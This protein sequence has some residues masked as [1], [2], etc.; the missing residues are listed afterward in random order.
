MAT[1]TKQFTRLTEHQADNPTPSASHRARTAITYS[2]LKEFHLERC[3]VDKDGKQRPK[4]SLKNEC[5]AINSWLKY[6]D[7]TPA[8]P[9]AE[10]LG[11]KFCQCLPQYLTALGQQ[12]LSERTVSDR[13]SIII[14]LRESFIAFERINDLPKNFSSALKHLIDTAS[15][16]VPELAHAT[17]I[18]KEVIITLTGG[19]RIPSCNSLAHIKRLERF[20]NL[21]PGTLSAKLPD[22]IWLKGPIRS[23]TTDWRKHQSG[24]LRLKYRLP[25]LTEQLQREWHEFMLSCTDSQWAN[26]QG[27]RTNSNW[28]VRWN[29]GRCGTAEFYYNLLQS[30]FGFL[31]LPMNEDKRI[32]GLGLSLPDLSLALLTDADLIMKY[33]YFMKGRSF[34]QSFNTATFNFLQLCMMLTRK[35]TGYLWQLPQFGAKLPRPVAESEWQSWCEKNRKKLRKF[36]KRIKRSKQDRVGMTRN[37]FEAVIDIIKERQHPITALFDLASRLESLTPLLEKGS[38][39]VLAAHRRSIFQV[40][41]ISSNPL[42]SENFSM[43]TYIPEDY[44]ALEQACNL[45]QQYKDR[46]QECDTSRLY[47]A[48]NSESNL[49]QRRDG[50][51]RLRFKEEDFKNWKGVALEPGVRRASY[52]VEVVPSVWP[53]LMEYLFRHRAVLNEGLLHVLRSIVSARALPALT[54]EQESAILRCPY[55]FRPFPSGI[56]AMPQDKFKIEYCSQQWSAKAFS[57]HMFSLTARYLPESKGFCAHACRHLVATEYIKNYPNGYEEAAVALHNTADMVR[58]HYSWVEV[59]DLIKPWSN[60]HE[61]IKGKHDRGEV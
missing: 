37:P 35:K 16:S 28:H 59:S 15:I 47:V 43:M 4:Q 12:E 1:S 6:H 48:A 50:S 14:K 51:W 54:P 27:L 11:L 52:D 30:Y 19:V 49:Y 33:L 7:L 3:G 23:C 26:E 25:N 39:T 17:S 8:H 20:F 53:A 42:R 13:K 57:A 60:H 61:E 18:S 46:Q 2:Q 34:S 5:S 44:G 32:S 9:V 45:Y 29:N 31:N 56:L 40:R 58:K 55:V 22:A 36:R 24:L 10:E 41:L 21:T 38:K